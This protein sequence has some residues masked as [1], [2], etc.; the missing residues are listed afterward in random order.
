MAEDTAAVVQTVGI[1]SWPESF[2]GSSKDGR[3]LT[4]ISTKMGVMICKSPE[5]FPSNTIRYFNPEC[6]KYGSGSC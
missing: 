2:T 6:Y 1:Q 3:N 5:P 4:L